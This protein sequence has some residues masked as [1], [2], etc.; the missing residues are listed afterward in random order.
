MNLTRENIVTIVSA[1]LRAHE[2]KQSILTEETVSHMCRH[3]V[4][5]F[6]LLTSDDLA[7]WDADPESFATDEACGT[8]KCSLRV[9]LSLCIL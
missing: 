9:S 4:T 6:F 7:L 2:T 5:H 8:W 3:L 1:T